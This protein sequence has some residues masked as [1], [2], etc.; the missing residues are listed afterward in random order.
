MFTTSHLVT[1][2]GRSVELW[3]HILGATHLSRTRFTTNLLWDRVQAHNCKDERES[4]RR[5]ALHE[6]QL[7]TNPISSPI[8]GSCEEK[9]YGI[10]IAVMGGIGHQAWVKTRAEAGQRVYA[11]RAQRGGPKCFVHKHV[12]IHAWGGGG[13]GLRR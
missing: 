2:E 4:S 8:E 10:S 12:S 3:Q 6:P 11:D 13:R 9:R 5:A 7:T 1:C